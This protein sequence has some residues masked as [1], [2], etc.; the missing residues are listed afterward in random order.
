MKKALLALLVL[1]LTTTVYG[2]LIKGIVLDEQ[3]G[4]PVDYASVF[5]NGTFVGTTTNEKGGFELDVSKY[6]TRPL[7]I[8]AVGYYPQVITDF[9]PAEIQRVLLKPRVFEIEEVS[10]VSKSL[11]RKRKACM[12]IFE[13]EFIGNTTN[14]RRC[15][16]LNEEDITFNY[17]SDKDTLKAYARRPLRIQNLSLGYDITYYLERFEYDRKNK[18]VL[19]TGSIIFNR[20][21]VTDEESLK[22]YERKREYAY[23]GSGK[24][25]FRVLWSNSLKSSGFEVK[26]YRTSDKLKYE[27]IVTE[28]VSGRKYLHYGEE[29]VIRYFDKLSYISF[30]K[31]KVYFEQDGFFDPT[32]IIWSG[33]IAKQRIADFLPYEYSFG[34]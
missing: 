3:T 23:T 4:S 19:Y 12:R 9:N 21:L 7:Y 32:G 18:T 20:D 28:E 24:H 26:N 13:H 17:A 6:R 27:N 1:C 29:L 8:S 22:R 5:F 15:Y 31:E 11:V 33:T 16:I 30:L 10:V 2:Q 14:A 25:F 34:R